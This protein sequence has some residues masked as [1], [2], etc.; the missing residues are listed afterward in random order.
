MTDNQKK[1]LDKEQK[2]LH[3]IQT[4]DHRDMTSL[5]ISTMT[6]KDHSKVLRDIRELSEDLEGF[7][8]N[9]NRAKFGFVDYVDA[10]GEKR[11]MCKLDA[12]TTLTL[13]TGYYPK[14]RFA[15]IKRWREL[16]TKEA[17]RQEVKLIG[18]EGYK[19]LMATVLF[20]VEDKKESAMKVASTVNKAVSNYFGLPKMIKMDEMNEEMLAVR[21][22]VMADYEKTFALFKGTDMSVKEFIYK[23]WQQ[24]V[25]GEKK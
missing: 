25:L 5:E 24:R 1:R 4:I 20:E 8:I 15:L 17:T 22:E 18:V 7:S 23:K 3:A 19:Q 13:L 16:E 9:G 12:D 21:V 11:P 10:K 6:G 14:G 2:T